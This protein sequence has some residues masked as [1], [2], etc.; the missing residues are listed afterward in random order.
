MSVAGPRLRCEWPAGRMEAGT[1][2][3][4]RMKAYGCVMFGDCVPS[5]AFALINEKRTMWKQER[6]SCHTDVG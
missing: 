4:S 1:S 6:R 3:S 2:D 5:G